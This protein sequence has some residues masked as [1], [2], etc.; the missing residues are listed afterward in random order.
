MVNV[1]PAIVTFPVRDSVGFSATEIRTEP[2]PLAAVWPATVI[3]GDSL[4]ALHA[5]ASA[6]VTVTAISA[7][8]LGIVLASSAL[9]TSE[10]SNEQDGTGDGDPD[11]DGPG[12]TL[13]AVGVDWEQPTAERAMTSP[14]RMANRQPLDADPGMGVG[15]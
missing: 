15:L 9:E 1:C 8:A 2:V 3:K 14:G 11:A 13:G 10:T 5:H 7:P 12:V 6:A 4:L